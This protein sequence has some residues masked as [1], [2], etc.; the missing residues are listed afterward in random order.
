MKENKNDTMIKALQAFEVDID[1]VIREWAAGN[2]EEK[3]ANH[4]LTLPESVRV[5]IVDA[6][7]IV[8]LATEVMPHL[9]FKYFMSKENVEY[10]IQALQQ[11]AQ[12]WIG[13]DSLAGHDAKSEE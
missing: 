1:D 3:T 12:Y 7:Y 8:M 4:F 13:L 11:I 2:D 10:V 9:G 5:S 6:S